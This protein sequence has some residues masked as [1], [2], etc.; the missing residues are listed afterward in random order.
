M[1]AGPGSIADA[2][3][4]HAGEHEHE[5]QVD[6][7]VQLAEALLVD[8]RRDLLVNRERRLGGL[9]GGGAEFSVEVL[10]G[11][12]FRAAPG[13]IGAEQKGVQHHIVTESAGFDAFPLKPSTTV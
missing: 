10:L 12:R 7:L 9:F 3:V 11:Q 2:L 13:G 6:L 5:R 1:R 4:L 8:V